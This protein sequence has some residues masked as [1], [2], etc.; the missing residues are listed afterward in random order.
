MIRPSGRT[1]AFSVTTREISDAAARS[2]PWYSHSGLLRFDDN[3]RATQTGRYEV[4]SFALPIPRNPTIVGH[5]VDH[6]N[7]HSIDIVSFEALSIS[8][9]TQRAQCA[10]GGKP[11]RA[12]RP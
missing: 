11:R 5:V 2:W 4:A 12:R 7:N 9:F 10:P 1:F 8:T 3:G 6:T